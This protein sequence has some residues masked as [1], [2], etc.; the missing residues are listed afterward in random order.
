MIRNDNRKFVQGKGAPFTSQQKKAIRSMIESEIETKYTTE[1]LST[2]ISNAG[3]FWQVT[4][5]GQGLQGYARVGDRIDVH[6]IELNYKITAPV[7]GLITAADV[8][9]TVRVILFRWKMDDAADPPA[10]TKILSAP[11]NAAHSDITQYNYNRDM[12]EKWSIIYDRTHVVYNQPVYDGTNVVYKPG[13]DHVY[14]SGTLEF[15]GKQCHG[16]S[17]NF[18]AGTNTGEGMIY[19]L[20]VSDSS[21]VPHP[22]VVASLQVDF[23]DA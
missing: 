1:G 22:S 21:F 2:T 12:Q 15:K 13:D 7:G 18:N 8:N 14:C 23:T 6:R 3:T 11:L 9:D 16:K 10:V 5:L 4:T 17:I 20:F 19:M